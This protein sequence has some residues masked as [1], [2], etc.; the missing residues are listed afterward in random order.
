MEER[1]VDA[2][3]LQCPRPVM[4]TKK[5]LDEMGDGVLRVLVTQEVQSRNVSQLAAA[6]ASCETLRD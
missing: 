1:Q 3:G 6:A 4:M 5:A 2:R